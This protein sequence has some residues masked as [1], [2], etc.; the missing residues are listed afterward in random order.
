METSGHDRFP[1][2]TTTATTEQQ[3][4]QTHPRPLHT[5]QLS[6]VSFSFFLFFFSQSRGHTVL[7]ASVSISLFFLHPDFMTSL[8]CFVPFQRGEAPV[9]WHRPTADTTDAEAAKHNLKL[10]HFPPSSPSFYDL[11]THTHTHLR[12]VISFLDSHHPYDV[13]HTNGRMFRFI[14]PVQ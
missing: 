10:R 2:H 5:A 7:C 12:I 8:F 3:E 9:Q 13:T 1:R 14:N 11:M 6:V 4:K